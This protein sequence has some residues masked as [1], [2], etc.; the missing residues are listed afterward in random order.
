MKIKLGAMFLLCV[1]VL[2]G[3]FQQKHEQYEF[4]QDFDRI[5]KIEIVKQTEMSLDAIVPVYVIKEFEPDEFRMVVDAILELDGGRVALDP[6]TGFGVYQIRITYAD[7]EIEIIGNYSKGY[8]SC[9]GVLHEEY[10]SLN[11][12]QYYEMISELLGEEIT[13]DSWVN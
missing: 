1:Y 5:Q 6:P 8:I 11:K 10:F 12:E 7:G 13:N 4:R 2:T 9:D 3:C